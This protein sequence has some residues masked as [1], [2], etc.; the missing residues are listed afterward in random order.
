MNY[1]LK[2]LEIK[3]K[4][5]ENNQINLTSK[6]IPVNNFSY[7]MKTDIIIQINFDL[8]LTRNNNYDN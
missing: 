7:K 1:K 2:T 8:I 6:K 4:G 3:S 5:F